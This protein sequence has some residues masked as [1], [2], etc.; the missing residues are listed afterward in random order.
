MKCWCAAKS[1]SVIDTKHKSCLCEACFDKRISRHGKYRYFRMFVS[2]RGTRFAGFQFQPE[3]RTVEG[4]LKK[5]LFSITQQDITITAA[6]RT[7]SGVHAHGQAI[8]AQFNTRLTQRQLLLALAS[9]LPADVAVW[10]V[11]EMLK[12]FDARR[13]SIG[14]QYIYRIDQ[15]LVSDPFMRDRVWQVKA[16]LDIEQMKIAAKFLQG[17]HDFSSFR[18]VHC[19]ASHAVRYLWRVG[20]VK[21]HNVIEVDVRGNA[22]CLNMVRIIVGTL[23]EVGRGRIAPHAIQNILTAQDR[24]AAGMTAPAHGLTFHKV[25][26]PDELNDALI[27]AGA[28]FPRYPVDETTWPFK[29]EDIIYGQ[30]SF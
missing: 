27:P 4:E 1:L 29:E 13:Q 8:S 11:D 30:S 28:Q 16:S 7:D 3:L 17:E 12:P 15:A 23:V 6:G 10:R 19:G 26:F 20:I 22:F 25:Y 14:K 24:K 2:Y 18:S 9:K 5:A 21:I